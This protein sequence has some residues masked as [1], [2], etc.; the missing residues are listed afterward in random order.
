MTMLIPDAEHDDLHLGERPLIVC[1]I[2]EVVL[3]FVSPFMAYL[4]HNG[5]ELRATSFRLHGNVFNRA[6]GS[7]TPGET[8]SEM[9]EAFFEAQDNWQTP[10]KEAADSLARLSVRADVVFLTAMP[11]RHREVRRRLLSRHGFDY[12]MI[13]TEQ[14]K[15]PAVLALHGER[16]HPV[17]FIDDIFVNLQSVRKHVP[18]T[19]LVNLMANDTFRALAPH[20]GDGVDIACDWPHAE[21]IIKTHFDG[22]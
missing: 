17:V 20:P 4:D 3:E 5:H 21:D 1:D 6:D 19:L 10:V 8:V 12:P 22:R 15:G 2:D 14:P 9:L 13:A 16:Q 7:E 11:P 18:D